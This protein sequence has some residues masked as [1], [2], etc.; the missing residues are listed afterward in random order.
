M[1]TRQNT[2]YF[3]PGLNLYLLST[4]KCGDERKKFSLRKISL[5][6][7][8]IYDNV[9]FS[10]DFS[11]KIRQNGIKEKIGKIR[12]NMGGRYENIAI[13]QKNFCGVSHDVCTCVC[14]AYSFS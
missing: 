4:Y 2:S 3:V 9:I 11:R 5:V 7:K 12:I 8:L 14:C 13:K 10:I 1:N 6:V